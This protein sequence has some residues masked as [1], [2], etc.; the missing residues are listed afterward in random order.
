MQ[1]K[2]PELLYA[3]LLLIIPILIHL[4][5]LRKFKKVAF[6]NVAF[7]QKVNIQTRKSNWIKKWLVLLSRLGVF[8]ML[9]LA[10]A[11]PYSTTT[12][13]ATKEKET[14]I[15]LDNSFSMQA[16]GPS[17]QL[18]KQAIQDLII[19]I[20]EDQ[21]FTLITNTDVYKDIT[22]KNGRNEL[23]MIPYV[24]TQ[25]VP[26]AITLKAKR[27]FSTNPA[28]EK[29]L[30][31]ISDFQEQDAPTFQNTTAMNSFLVPLRPVVQNNIVL[32]SVYVAERSA[33]S[34][35]LDVVISAAELQKDN[36]PVSLYDGE[37]LVAKA[38]ISLEENLEA[39]TRFEIDA[40]TI[41]EGRIAIEDPLL[42]FDNSLYFNLNTTK[43]IRVLAI[44]EGP[45]DYLSRVYAQPE[46]SLDQVLFNDLDYS[47]LSQYDLV[48]LNEVVAPTIAL[49]SA[50]S[51]IQEQGGSL[52]VIPG[53]ESTVA[54][55]RLFLER[56]QGIQIDALNT[57]PK[58]LTTINYDHPLYNRVF[59][60]RIQN[61]QYPSV[62]TYFEGLSGDPI[63]Q[64]EDGNAFL[65]VQNRMYIV[66]G[67]LN[68]QN[69]NLTNAPLI[70]PTLY[71]IGAQSKVILQLYYTI[72]QVNT[73][74]TSISLTDDTVLKL[75]GT[76][77]ATDEEQI[78]L[79]QSFGN[80]VSITTTDQPA[81]N[82]SYTINYRDSIIDQ[83]SYNYDRRESQLRYQQ[84]NAGERI[85]IQNSIESLFDDFKQA[86]TVNSLWKWFI[87]FALLF[88]L[89][90][91]V[92]L[93]F[94]K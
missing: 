57:D 13:T 86:D 87:I 92:L 5:Q 82:G 42:K 78:P 30:I 28:T 54:Q 6:T 39:T 50:L 18:L 22:I 14:V 70:V 11:Q 60:D 27:E 16:K 37:Q 20:P 40:N 90:E 76:T 74:D 43:P 7:L 34:I 9:I 91:V 4:F 8:T 58:L 1:F 15:Y 48:V 41:F 46:F 26:E 17:G 62:T 33:N 12:E 80:R 88:L 35:S 53:T 65:S 71:N 31:L 25:L 55:Y 47:I 68:L 59:E 44:N 66:A 64:L 2:H 67:A 75:K 24:T 85:S 89:I 84:L 61:F 3:L 93:K 49:A 72:G 73:Y 83:V 38:T 81:I 63:L 10:F 51:A 45:S 36:I 32:D 94:L 21:A 56:L 79:Q 77:P 52:L 29:R 23:L 69:T 19:N